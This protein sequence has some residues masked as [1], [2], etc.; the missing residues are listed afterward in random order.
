MSSRLARTVIAL[1]AGIVA[2]WLAVYI[3]FK[4][5]DLLEYVAGH[6][7]LRFGEGEP[8]SESATAAVVTIAGFSA[9]GLIAFAWIVA[10]AG[11][12]NFASS[13][14]SEEPASE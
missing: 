10:I 5:V 1:G 6:R 14:N 3:A 7:D 8:P 13:S 12:A 9:L 2:T 4:G 11:L